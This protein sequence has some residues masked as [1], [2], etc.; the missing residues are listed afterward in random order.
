VGAIGTPS[1]WRCLYTDHCRAGSSGGGSSQQY[2]WREPLP[3][4]SFARR[5]PAVSFGPGPR[6]HASRS[7]ASEAWRLAV[8]GRRIAHSIKTG[9]CRAVIAWVTPKGRQPRSELRDILAHQISIS[10]QGHTVKSHFLGLCSFPGT[11]PIAP[12]SSQSTTPRLHAVLSSPA[13]QTAIWKD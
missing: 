6:W 2:D 13:Q 3:S 8:G 11:E 1:T 7:H 4:S 5:W 10:R 9:V 12:M